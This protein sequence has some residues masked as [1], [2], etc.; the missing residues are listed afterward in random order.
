[1]TCVFLVYQ[2]SPRL[3]KTGKLKFCALHLPKCL[4]LKYAY[5]KNSP[6][7]CCKGINYAFN[8]T[9]D[10]T[11]HCTVTLLFCNCSLLKGIVSIQSVCCLVWLTSNPMFGSDNFRINHHRDFRK[12]WNWPRFTRA[13][14]LF[15]KIY[16]S[17]LSQIALT[18][19]WLLVLIK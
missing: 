15:S 9:I 2:F 11:R 13:I 4:R 6:K 17:N 7:N 10:C 12:F 5:Y 1:M 8:H 18:N 3:N 16:L 14:S 19:M